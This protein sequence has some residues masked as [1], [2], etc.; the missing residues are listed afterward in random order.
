MKISLRELIELVFKTYVINICIKHLFVYC[1]FQGLPLLTSKSADN[2]LTTIGI[3]VNDAKQI[4]EK[5]FNC[6]RSKRKEGTLERCIRKRGKTV[7]VVAVK[8]HNY[9]LETDCWLIIHAGIF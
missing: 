6:E 1:K 7:K 9:S 2:E 8:S 4:L 3:T 5:G